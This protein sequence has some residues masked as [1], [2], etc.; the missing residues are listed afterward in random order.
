MLYLCLKNPDLVKVEDFKLERNIVSSKSPRNEDGGG[1][2]V[3]FWLRNALTL[4]GLK[5]TVMYEVSLQLKNLSLT[6]KNVSLFDP[7][8]ITNFTER[9]VFSINNWNISS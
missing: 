1:R 6:V 2:S 4:L 8:H 3:R 5:G 7:I 9:K